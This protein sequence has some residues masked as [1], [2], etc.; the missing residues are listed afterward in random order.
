ME[1]VDGDESSDS[2]VFVSPDTIAALQ[3]NIKPGRDKNS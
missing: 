1:C 2:E 3:A